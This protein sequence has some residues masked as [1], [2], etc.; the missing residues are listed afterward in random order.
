MNNTGPWAEA[1]TL[2]V[3]VTKYYT[4]GGRRACP[5]CNR[6]VAM[7]QGGV[8]YYLH[9]DHLGSTNLVTDHAA[10]ITA[11][12]RYFPYGEVR[13]REGTLPTDF[14]FTGQ[15][16]EAGLGLLDYRARFYAP[17]LGRFVSA[18]TLVP[19]PGN[20]Q[21]LNRYAYVRNNPLRYADPS[22]HWL[23]EETPNDPYFIGPGLYEA[24]RRQDFITP[25]EPTIGE[26]ILVLATPYASAATVATASVAT[27]AEAATFVMNGTLATV[28]YTGGVALTNW[29]R[30]KP[31]WEG[32]S[33]EDA[34]ASFFTGGATGFIPGKGFWA[35]FG[36]G[37][38]Q[39]GSSYVLGQGLK[40]EPLSAGGTAASTF[41]GG[42]G[43]GVGDE[44]AIRAE[45]WLQVY[46]ATAA[47]A[48]KVGA[49]IGPTADAFQSTLKDMVIKSLQ[50][51][52]PTPPWTW[53]T[54]PYTLP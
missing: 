38:T 54:T 8:V 39:A 51:P 17:V 33:F 15:R 27:T 4:F 5:E 28:G 3:Q 6:R 35:G 16:V 31:T 10:R 12:Q 41:F 1:S 7:R 34:M 44:L 25:H 52:A 13:W 48:G 49:V 36:R 20:P 9:A 26:V 23:F 14:A 30:G 2:V 42:L 37:A 43:G 24:Q 18:D 40:G 29:A 19:N 32:W 45:R 50:N 53:P 21:D 47:A 22:G 11:R 46:P